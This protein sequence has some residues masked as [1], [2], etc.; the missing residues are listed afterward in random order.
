MLEQQKVNTATSPMSLQTQTNN[1]FV[2]YKRDGSEIPFKGLL[3]GG[4]IFTFDAGL[5]VEDNEIVERALPNGKSERYIVLD[6]GFHSKVG[7]IS[8]H[9]QMVV[10]KENAVAAPSHLPTAGVT[11]IYNVQGPNARVN[12]HSVDS[13]YNL[14]NI[15]ETELFEKMRSAIESGVLDGAQKGQLLAAVKELEESAGSPAF[16]ERFQKLLAGAA[17]CM[18]ILVPF[19]PAL[20]QLAA[21][22]FG[23]N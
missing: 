20:G 11:N 23:S 2:L 13:S 22:A 4:K 3:A 7:R 14:A 1:P 8:D 15:G 6:T 12:L 16:A 10:Q 18:T 19:L 5:P 17:D 9:F 21:S